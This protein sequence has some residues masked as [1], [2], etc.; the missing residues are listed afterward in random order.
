MDAGRAYMSPV[1]YAKHCAACHGLQFDTRFQEGAPHDTPEVIRAFLVQKF[2]QYI[3]SHPAELRVTA[4]NRNLPDQP[5]R[6][7]VRV[8][9]EQQWVML[10]VAESEQLLYRKTCAQCHAL[11]FVANAPWPVVVK[12]NITQRWFQH[13]CLITIPTSS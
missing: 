1:T 8:L 5:L 13:A 11:Q 6:P 2:Q 10:R 7:A 3:P 12:S 4:P 9:T